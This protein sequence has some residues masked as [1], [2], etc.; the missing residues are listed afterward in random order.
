M[1]AS[2]LTAVVGGT[3][4]AASSGSVTPATAT[5]VV[6]PYIATPS[7]VG[8]SA[9][10]AKLPKGKTADCLETTLASVITICQA[11]QQA[12]TL[13]GMNVTIV[14]AGTTA[15]DFTNAWTQILQSPPTVVVGDSFPT[16]TYQA[17][18]NQYRSHGGIYIANALGNPG[19]SGVPAGVSFMVATN[20]QFYNI[21]VLQASFLISQSKG[22]ANPIFYYTKTYPVLNSEQQGFASVWNKCKTCSAAQYETVA[23]T[24]IGTTLPARMVSDLQRRPSTNWIVAGYGELLTGVP[25]ALQAA[26]LNNKVQL[27]FQAG[28][29][30][31]ITQLK[32]GAIQYG[33]PQPLGWVG[34]VLADAA[35]RLSTGQKTAKTANTFAA[36]PVQFLNPKRMNASTTDSF[37]QWAGPPNYAAQFQKL[38]GIGNCTGT[39]LS[40]KC[41]SS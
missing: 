24:E 37:G 11:F 1:A 41:K 39:G 23:G 31:D 33:L 15:A 28:D 2:L 34:Y 26:G 3:A 21:G 9:A 25:Q 22:K 17:Q 35:A 20:Q 27:T 29:A 8:V 12:A 30:E 7:S 5:K 13:L 10:L 32:S 14:H 6:A 19:V 16:S 4:G 36:T 18:L 40:V 38:W